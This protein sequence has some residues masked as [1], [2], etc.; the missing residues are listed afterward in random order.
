MNKCLIDSDSD[1]DGDNNDNCL[2]TEKKN[3]KKD[4]STEITISENKIYKVSELNYEIQNLIKKQINKIEITG[5]ITNLSFRNHLY[6]SLKDNDS[7]IDCFLWESIYNKTNIEIKNGDKIVCKGIFSLYHRLGKL[8]L[9]LESYYLDGQGELQQKFIKQKNELELLGYFDEKRK[10]K[11]KKYNNKIGIVTSI[12][13]AAYQDILSVI[14]RKNCYVNL[15]VSD[16]RVQGNK[17]EID[18]CKSLLKLD[19][20]NLDV[21][22]LTR[23]GGSLED[24]WGFNERKL[25]E[26][27]YNCQTPI[28]S[29]VGHQIDFTLSD[30]TSDI[31]AITPSIGG[32]IAV[33]NIT[34]IVKIIEETYI[35]IKNKVDSIFNNLQQELKNK[36]IKLDSLYPVKEIISIQ[37]KIESIFDKINIES[38]NKTDKYLIKIDENKKKLELINPMNLLKKGYSIIK[39]E[40]NKSIKSIKDIKN[41]KHFK[42]VLADG[43]IDIKL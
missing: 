30:Y 35:N 3:H 31:R 19:N 38:K 6:F 20:L 9:T 8:Q 41:L 24:L 42:L 7:K 25:I 13:S 2:V 5:E 37:N 4:S 12:D 17:C 40:D 36:L 33:I 43:E 26:T 39:N 18:I 32:D 21:I 10:K 15:F 27:I 16:C 29:A 34:D 11:L 28:I 1:G 22:I 14:K 23:G